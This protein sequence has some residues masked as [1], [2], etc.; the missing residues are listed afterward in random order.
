LFTLH[1]SNSF[2]KQQ[3]AAQKVFNQITA[4]A[5]GRALMS[6]DGESQDSENDNNE[7]KSSKIPF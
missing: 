6:G 1:A 5:E 4:K 3:A 7:G 2:A